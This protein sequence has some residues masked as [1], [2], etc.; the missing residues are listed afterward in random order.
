MESSD[1]ST[2]PL[3]VMAAPPGQM[4]D[5]DGHVGEDEHPVIEAPVGNEEHVVEGGPPGQ[6]AIS[7]D[8]GELDRNHAA[9]LFELRCQASG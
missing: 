7:Q 8:G 5:V 9:R 1:H 2:A 6:T 4:L 3:K